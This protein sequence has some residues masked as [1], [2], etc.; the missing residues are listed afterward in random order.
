MS[1]ETKNI[2]LVGNCQTFALEKCLNLYENYEVRQIM[3]HSETLN[4]NDYTILIN[5]YD[6]IITQPISESYRELD[7]L[8]T[9][10][11]IDNTKNNTIIIFPSCYFDF[12]YPDLIYYGLSEPVDYHYVN[13]INNFKDNSSIENYITHCVNNPNLF[14]KEILLEKAENSFKEMERRD[15]EVKDYILKRKNIYYISIT[16]FVKNNFKEKLLFYS[17]NHPSKYLIHYISE[18]IISILNIPNSILYNLDPL[19]NPKC[20]LYSCINNV[21][22]FDVNKETIKLKDKKTVYLIT[23]LYYEVY[24]NINLQ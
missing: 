19:D 24:S 5:N 22:N 23:K 16:N 4:K 10:Y 7:Y 15:F 11:L 21:V 9:N 2:L 20:I 13:M 3:I 17:M 6:I 18:E 12:Y 8:G 14:S 1:R